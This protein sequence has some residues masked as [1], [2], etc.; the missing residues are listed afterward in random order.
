[1]HERR[2][3]RASVGGFFLKRGG[4]SVVDVKRLAP[5][6]KGGWK[7]TPYERLIKRPHRPYGVRID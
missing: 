3:G 4:Y 7:E 1:M 6:E 5:D 2:E